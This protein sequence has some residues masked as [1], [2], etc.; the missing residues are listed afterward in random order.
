[1]VNTDGTNVRTVTGGSAI[2]DVDW[3]TITA[4]QALDST[5]TANDTACPESQTAPPSTAAPM[6]VAPPAQPLSLRITTVAFTPRVLRTHKP[7]VLK[8]VVRDNVDAAVPGATVKVSSPDGQV[9]AMNGKTSSNGTV[10][11]VLSPTKRL[12][13]GRVV[14]IAR[15]TKAPE[16]AAQ[17]LISIRRG[18]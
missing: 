5:V 1:M 13:G 3:G 6:P 17:R 16:T 14:L 2:G 18:V 8:L 11:L 10:L 12:H 7:F 15:A 4:T 9:M